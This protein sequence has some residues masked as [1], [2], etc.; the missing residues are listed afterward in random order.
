MASKHTITRGISQNS[1]REITD[2]MFTAL[3]QLWLYTSSWDSQTC[4][5]RCKKNSFLLSAS[6]YP[7]Y[8][9]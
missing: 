3:T 5:M 4:L 2:A 9:T 1:D 8:Y 7:V 6:A